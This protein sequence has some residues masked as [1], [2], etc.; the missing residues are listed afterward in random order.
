MNNIRPAEAF[1]PARETTNFLSLI[2]NTFECFKTYQLW[3]LDMSKKDWTAMRFELCITALVY[4]F[5]IK[6]LYTVL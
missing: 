4:W 2:K 6:L 1:N 3:L 5:P